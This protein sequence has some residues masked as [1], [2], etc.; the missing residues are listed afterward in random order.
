MEERSGADDKFI[1]HP[2]NQISSELQANNNSSKSSLLI[3]TEFRCTFFDTFD[4]AIEIVGSRLNI[5]SS[6]ELQDKDNIRKDVGNE[7]SINR[8][9]I[10][11]TS[12]FIPV[13]FSLFI[14]GSLYLE[15]IYNNK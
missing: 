12:Q 4:T 13:I 7:F 1:K 6:F 14:S 11:S 2:Q 15:S 3:V 5:N 8:R 9:S 10:F